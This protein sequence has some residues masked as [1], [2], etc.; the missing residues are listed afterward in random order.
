MYENMPIGICENCGKPIYFG[1]RI[2][3][4]IVPKYEK[5]WRHMDTEHKKC[6][7]TIPNAWPVRKPRS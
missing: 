4:N 6:F 5:V 3:T 7:G 2:T 1:P